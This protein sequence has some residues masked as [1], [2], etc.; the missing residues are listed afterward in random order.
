MNVDLK[1]IHSYIYIMFI[2]LYHDIKSA[3]YI[4]LFLNND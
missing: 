2:S 3:L 1:P 4:Y